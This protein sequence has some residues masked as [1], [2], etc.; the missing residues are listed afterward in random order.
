MTVYICKLAVLPKS[1]KV[2]NLRASLN[3]KNEE[4]RRQGLLIICKLEMIK[5]YRKCEVTRNILSC[6]LKC[7]W[8]KVSPMT[9]STKCWQ[10]L[11]NSCIQ[12]HGIIILVG[13]KITL[14]NLDNRIIGFCHFF[15]VALQRIVC[16]KSKVKPPLA[17]WLSVFSCGL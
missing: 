10:T 4:Y 5:Q 15:C 2:W 16:W 12:Q 11:K 6:L 9:I 7:L 1:S 3:L 8:L 14:W 17:M 13:C